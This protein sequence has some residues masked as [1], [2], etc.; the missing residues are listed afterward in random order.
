M[1]YQRVHI[2]DYFQLVWGYSAVTLNALIKPVTCLYR[3]FFHLGN[4]L[5]LK[6]VDKS[7]SIN[8]V[9]DCSDIAEEMFLKI[10]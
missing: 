8:V 6:N 4:V 5:Q 10:T 2:L 7:N 3:L 9:N 1:F